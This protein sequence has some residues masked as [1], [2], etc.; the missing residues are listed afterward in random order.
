MSNEATPQDKSRGVALLPLGGIHL[1][2]Q[3]RDNFRIEQR[4]NFRFSKN[5][6][7]YSLAGDREEDL[8]GEG[9]YHDKQKQ[10]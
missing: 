3:Q 5:R 7:R 1:L 9:N 6:I 8:D 2:S 4:K 10:G